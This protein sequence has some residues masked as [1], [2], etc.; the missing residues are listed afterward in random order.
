MKLLVIVLALG[1]LLVLAMLPAPHGR[2]FDSHQG[3][4]PTD[5]HIQD[6]LSNPL[7]FVPE[8]PWGIPFGLLQ[9]IMLAVALIVCHALFL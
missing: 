3:N 4:H 5:G 2:V 7:E 1:A 6:R 9:G 8:A